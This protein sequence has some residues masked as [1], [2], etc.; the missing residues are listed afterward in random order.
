MTQVIVSVST[1]RVI[2][3]E[4]DKTDQ[5]SVYVKGSE[6]TQNVVDIREGVY[7]GANVKHSHQED[8]MVTCDN[9][10]QENELPGFA[11]TVETY[12][13]QLTKLG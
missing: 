6:K 5:C 10:P 11:E 4:S 12:K 8:A 1:C 3:A 9:F 7:L 13:A 2:Q